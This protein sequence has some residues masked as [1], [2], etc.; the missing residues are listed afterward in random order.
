MYKNVVCSDIDGTLLNKDRQLSQKTIAI[1]KSISPVPFILISSRMPKAMF[2]LQEELEITNLP[3]VAYNG[4]LIVDQ[5]K[6]LHSEEIDLDVAEQIFK[7]CKNTSIHIS[8]Y[9]NDEWFVPAMDYWA[10]RERNNTKVIPDVHPISNTLIKW[11][12]E[13]KGAHKIMCMGE[14]NEIEKLSIFLKE[15]FENEVIGYRSKETYL[16]ISPK[17]ISKKTAINLL[18]K[19]KYPE[20]RLENVIAFGDNYNDIEMLQSV[21][22]G[23][24]V[25]NANDA[26][27]AIA[28]NKTLSNKE[29]GVAVFLE[30]Y[31]SKL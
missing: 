17:N 1:V 20:I 30:S 14:E 26:V 22:V 3:M 4:A 24:A 11:L 6:I 10:D 7:F 19:L 18:L 2:H 21:G 12:E 25:Q 27:L 8:L 23:V 31:F 9:H 5:N 15:E 16:E 29:D 28:K 13:H